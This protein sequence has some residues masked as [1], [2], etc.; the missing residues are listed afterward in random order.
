VSN[1]SNDTVNRCLASPRSPLS[2][3]ND[4]TRDSGSLLAR[5]DVQDCGLLGFRVIV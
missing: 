4:L 2:T 1:V 5:L 3:V